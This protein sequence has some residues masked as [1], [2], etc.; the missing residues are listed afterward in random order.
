MTVTVVL[1]SLVVAA[2]CI[3]LF[4]AAL[5]VSRANREAANRAGATN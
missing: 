2:L 1:I 3:G 4:A 5:R